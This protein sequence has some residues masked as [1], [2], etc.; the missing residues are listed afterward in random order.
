LGGISQTPFGQSIGQGI[1]NLFGSSSPTANAQQAI[2][3][4]GAGNVYG[5]GGSGTVPTIDYSNPA[6]IVDWEG[7]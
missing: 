1:S 5:F 7:G 3:Q 2:A 6:N 4:Y